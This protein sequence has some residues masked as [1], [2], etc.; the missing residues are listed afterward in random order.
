MFDSLLSNVCWNAD[1]YTS[2]EFRR[3]IWTSGKKT[4]AKLINRSNNKS[5]PDIF[6][7]WNIRLT[8]EMLPASLNIFSIFFMSWSYFCH[9]LKKIILKCRS[10][11]FWQPCLRFLRFILKFKAFFIILNEE[12][13]NF[14]LGLEEK[15]AV[16][17]K[18]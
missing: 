12:R 17:M 8:T 3:L 7:A 10:F 1:S 6:N 15:T 13:I 2:S 5:W 9:T 14:F 18:L 16:F 11:S 4:L